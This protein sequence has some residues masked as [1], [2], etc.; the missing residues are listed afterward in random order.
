MHDLSKGPAQSFQ[1]GY[2]QHQLHILR[3]YRLIFP[4]EL[5][6]PA[7]GPVRLQDHMIRQATG[8]LIQCIPGKGG[9]PRSRLAFRPAEGHF[10]VPGKGLFQL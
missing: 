10:F 5:D 8:G 1:G 4:M 7:P 9:L 6:V 2:S 3:N